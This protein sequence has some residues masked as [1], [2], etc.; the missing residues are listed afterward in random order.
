MFERREYEDRLARTRARMAARGVDALIVDH[1]E[2]LAWLTGYTVSET[3]YRAALVPCA[4]EPCFVLRSLD[5][6]PC[7]RATWFNEVIGFPD[8][9]DPHAVVADVIRGRGL[10]AGCI[11]AD[12][13]SY[14][15]SAHTRDRLTALLPHAAFVPLTGISDDLR[16]LK[17]PAE[18]EVLRRAA[19]IADAAMA[20]VQKAARP[21]MTAREA[22][23]VAGAEFLLRGADSGDVG[24]IVKAAGESG[25]LH[26][27]LADDVLGDGDI[28][29]VELVPK[30]ANYSARLMRPILTGRDQRGLA[31]IAECLVRLQD[32]QIAAMTPGVP[33]RDVDAILREGVLASSLRRTYDNVTGYTLGI[34]GRTPRASDFSRAFLPNAHW[35]LEAGMVFHMYVSAQGLGFSETVV[36]AEDGGQRLTRTP[37]RILEAGTPSVD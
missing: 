28:L 8:S 14:G 34:Y 11:G 1:A 12:F 2:L 21:G 36:V 32:R 22:A 5:V 19:G 9:A 18:V 13:R 15:F 30:V 25:F 23:A 33:A 37:R 10:E 29:H 6:E 35:R 3:M 24:P 16:A 31:G 17:S 7:R 4:G 20:A 26:A 27:A